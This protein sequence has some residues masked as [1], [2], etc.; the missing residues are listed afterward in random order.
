MGILNLTPDSFSDGGRF[1]K[2]DDVLS[3]A[4]FM[5]KS[6]VDIIDVGAESTRPGSD[7]VD[8]KT[9]WHRIEEI[10]PHLF[11]L[12]V[13]IS[14]DS[15]KPFVMRKALSSGID[16][17][18]DVSGFQLDETLKI[19]QDCI[20]DNIGYCI[21]HMQGTP[22]NMQDCPRY[23]D[24][25]A[26]VEH[27]LMQR[28]EILLS[29]GV[30]KNCLLI[31][32]GFGFGKTTDHNFELLQALSRL[33]KIAPVLVGISRKRLIAEMCLRDCAPNDRLGGSLAAAIWSMSQGASVVR[34]HDV[35]ETV[36]GL[37]VFHSL[38]KI[39]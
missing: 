4:A 7:E 18:N 26:E 19:V 6:G 17:I 33:R 12:K 27:F 23:V 39:E 28:Y 24:V 20:K 14:I 22:Q 36:D 5:V 10:V 16:M 8:E 1:L 9:E 2:I 21:M 13:P 29:L 38:S 35:K 32:P 11:E 37:R 25:V 15:R 3:Y 30:K 34:V 31:D